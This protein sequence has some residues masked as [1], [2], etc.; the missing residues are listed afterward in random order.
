MPK[1]GLFLASLSH[2][3]G[4]SAAHYQS[5]VNDTLPLSRCLLRTSHKGSKL[6]KNIDTIDRSKK[7]R[8]N[9]ATRGVSLTSEDG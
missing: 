2:A 9:T 7:T 5:P 3:R 6:L 4:A 8:R 1:E